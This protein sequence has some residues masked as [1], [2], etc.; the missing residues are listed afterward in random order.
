[1]ILSGRSLFAEGMA[2]RLGQFL[3][4]DELT[5]VD[6][7]DPHALQAVIAAQPAA[8][9]LEA[10]DETVTQLDPLPGLLAALPTLRIV[11]LDA[12]GHD[13]QVITSARRTVDQAQDLIAILKAN[14]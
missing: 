13:V 4:P 14:P 5:R 3:R 10:G 2:T 7:R 12:R 1:M 6:A 11:Q 9:L 8:V